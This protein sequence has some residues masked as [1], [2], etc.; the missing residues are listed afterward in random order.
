M[1][2]FVKN[3]KVGD[4][5]IVKR[6]NKKS[7]CK[8]DRITPK[9]YIGIGKVLFNEDGIERGGDPWYGSILIEANP[10]ELRKAKEEETLREAYLLMENSKITVKQAEQ[11]INILKGETK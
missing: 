6:N 3:L 5:V 1:R 11:I 7:V 4:P 2:E 10:E 9:G 8:I